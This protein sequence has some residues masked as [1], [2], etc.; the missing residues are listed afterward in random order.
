MDGWM[1]ADCVSLVSDESYNWLLNQWQGDTT[2]M[3]FDLNLSSCMYKTT[4]CS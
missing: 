1:H 4:C 3:S 2:L